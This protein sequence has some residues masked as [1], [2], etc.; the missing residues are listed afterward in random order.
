MSNSKATLRNLLGPGKRHQLPA[1]QRGAVS[2]R[3]RAA[4]E[5]FLHGNGDGKPVTGTIR[6]AE[7]AGIHPGTVE[8]YR[9]VWERE[10]KAMALE[11]MG[12]GKLGREVTASDLQ[13]HDANILQLQV[14]MERLKSLL[15]SLTAGSDAHRDT[16]KL[17]T[18]TVKAWTEE[19]GLRAHFEAASAYAKEMART[20]ARASRTSGDTAPREVTGFDFSITQS[21]SDDSGS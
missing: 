19:S 9:P 13:L 10:R 20:A 1:K 2:A 16:L 15:P 8:K 11:T 4:R 7:L 6:L 5:L 18:A 14:E 12:K 3:T 21:S 17:Y